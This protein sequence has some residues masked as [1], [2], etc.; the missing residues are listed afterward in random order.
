M[1]RKANFIG[2]TEKIRAEF[3]VHVHGLGYSFV[4][5]EVPK[6]GL[7]YRYFVLSTPI[8]NGKVNLRLGLSM[9]KVVNKWKVNPAL[10]LLPS[11]IVN[12]I[13]QRATFKGYIHDVMQDFDIWKNKTYIAPP[14]FAKGDGPVG[15]YRQW[16]K[17]FYPEF[18]RESVTAM[19]E[20]CQPITG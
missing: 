12:A 18:H 9:K 6:Y 2:K 19:D 13:I 15:K 16:A 4:E 17:Q 20:Q 8:E 14:A 5:A 1:H 10:T 11:P 7:Q 3:E